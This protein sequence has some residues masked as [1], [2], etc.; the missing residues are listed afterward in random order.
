MSLAT[1]S[2]RSAAPHHS[3]HQWV[4]IVF[5]LLPFFGGQFAP[6]FHDTMA[7]TLKAYASN[8]GPKH[9]AQG[10]LVTEAD[11]SAGLLHGHL[12]VFSAVDHWTC[13]RVG[14]LLPLL[15]VNISEKLLCHSSRRLSRES[16]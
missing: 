3:G 6:L 13:H 10:L 1:D 16:S 7:A 5:N 9:L 8:L 14:V 2:S 11:L 12:F 15:A 4:V